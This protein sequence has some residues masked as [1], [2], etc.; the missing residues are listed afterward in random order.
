MEAVNNPED[1][2]TG[3]RKVPFSKILFIEQEDFMENPPPKFFRLAPGNEVR[4]K[5]AYIIKCTNIIKD[6]NGKSKKCIALMIR[7]HEA[8]H[9][10][11]TAK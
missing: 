2:E 7:K 5:Y 10:K 3:I 6:E 8:D 1:A 9:H 11:A 4:L